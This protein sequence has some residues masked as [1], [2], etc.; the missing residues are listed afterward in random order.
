MFSVITGHSLGGVLSLCRDAIGVFYSPSGLGNGWLLVEFPGK[1]L[2]CLKA[3]QISKKQVTKPCGWLYFSRL[4]TLATQV[5][6][7]VLVVTVYKWWE[8]AF[9]C[10]ISAISSL[11]KI[12][13]YTLSIC[14]LVRNKFLYLLY[15]NLLSLFFVE[16]WHKAIWMGLAVRLRLNRVD[17]RVELAKHYTTRGAPGA[18]LIKR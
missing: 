18:Y 7:K 11:A 2:I 15:G 4:N 1:L 5:R 12:K 16:M 10:L 8:V 14:F 17:L 13:Y 6:T 9:W 3:Y